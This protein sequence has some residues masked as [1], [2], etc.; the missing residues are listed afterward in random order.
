MTHHPDPPLPLLHDH[1]PQCRTQQS[2]SHPRK[3]LELLA[4]HWNVRKESSTRVEGHLNLVHDTKAHTLYLHNQNTVYS[5][6]NLRISVARDFLSFL[7][8]DGLS[9]IIHNEIINVCKDLKKNK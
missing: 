9:I 8:S 7:F 2:Q 1:T 5:L 4:K 6:H 3:S